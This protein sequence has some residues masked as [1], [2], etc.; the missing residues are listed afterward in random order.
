MSTFAIPL[1][2]ELNLFRGSII[3]ENLSSEWKPD[4]TLPVAKALFWIIPDKWLMPAAALWASAI[5]S[6]GS[7]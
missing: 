7:R 5:L 3:E 6:F 4:C 1:E 2:M